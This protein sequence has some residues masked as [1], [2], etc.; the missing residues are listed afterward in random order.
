[1][2]QHV[3]RFFHAGD[4]AIAKSFCESQQK[5]PLTSKPLH[6]RIA[7]PADIAT[8]FDIRQAAIQ[9]L[10]L[11]HLSNDEAAAWAERGGIGRVERALANDDVW[12]ATHGSQSFGWIHRTGNSIEGLYVSPSA[13]SRGVGAG[14]MHFAET[15]IAQEG[16]QVINLESSLNA[17][18][19]YLRL[20]YIPHAA[21]T[22]SVAIRLRKQIA[23]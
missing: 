3:G 12:I 21:Q 18:G 11:T 14:L 16:H 6:F 2:K 20:G 15:R 5:Y 23:T 19:F 1:L 22:S 9:Q 7:T 4:V 17:L 10:T 8:L 13:A